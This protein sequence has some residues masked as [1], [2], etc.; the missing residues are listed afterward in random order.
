MDLEAGAV[1]DG[2]DP[3]EA[4]VIVKNGDFIM[5]T[6]AATGRSLRSHGHRAPITKRHFQVCGYGDVRRDAVL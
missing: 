1:I 5:L 2:G 4:P 3:K 6:H